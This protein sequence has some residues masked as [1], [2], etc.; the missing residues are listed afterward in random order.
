[1]VG[2]HKYSQGATSPRYPTKRSGPVLSISTD[3]DHGITHSACPQ[4]CKTSCIANTSWHLTS[5]QRLSIAAS[6]GSPSISMIASNVLLRI[7]ARHKRT[8]KKTNLKV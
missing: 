3:A 8:T 5:W 7:N 6:P 1:M 2:H 4:C